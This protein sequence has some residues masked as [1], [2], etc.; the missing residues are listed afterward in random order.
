MKIVLTEEQVA[1]GERPPLLYGFA[2]NDLLNQRRY[3]ILMPFNLIARGLRNLW[4]WLKGRS[5]SWS[6][7]RERAIYQRAYLDAMKQIDRRIRMYL[8]GV[9]K[10]EDIPESGT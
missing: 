5:K 4:H 8:D 7:E 6:E 1:W 2:W 9:I 10:R 3:F